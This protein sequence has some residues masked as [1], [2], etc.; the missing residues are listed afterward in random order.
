MPIEPVLSNTNTISRPVS[1]SSS[2][3]L[4]KPADPMPEM[5]RV[6]L[7]PSRGLRGDVRLE[8]RGLTFNC[9]SGCSGG[10]GSM[11]GGFSMIGS[12]SRSGGSTG[13]GSTSGTRTSESADEIAAP[14]TSRLTVASASPLGI[15]AGYS[16]HSAKMSAAWN[17]A[18]MPS[19]GARRSSSAMSSWKVCSSKRRTAGT[20]ATR[21]RPAAATIAGIGAI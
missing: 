9:P 8:I 1:C 18:E 14:A 13:S 12:S 6:R 3:V 5:L 7:G 10:S 17:S 19:H 2:T 11:T 20:G 16:S 15:R 4:R 21:R